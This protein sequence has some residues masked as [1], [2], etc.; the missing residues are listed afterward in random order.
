MINTGFGGTLH[1]HLPRWS[2]TIS[3]KQ[4]DRRSQ[5]VH[6]VCWKHTISGLCSAGEQIWV[7]S[8][9]SS[10]HRPDSTGISGPGRKSGRPGGS[11]MQRKYSGSS[12]AS[13][14]N[15]RSGTGKNLCVFPFHNAF[16]LNQDSKQGAVPNHLFDDPG[17]SL[18]V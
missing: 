16:P 7:N 10:G 2:Q 13:G 9:P 12:V 6:P 18:I 11:H 5:G 3:H 14:R 1:Q 8:L 4:T 15:E 17:R